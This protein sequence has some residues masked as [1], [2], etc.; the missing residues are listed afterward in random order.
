MANSLRVLFQKIA[1]AQDERELQRRFMDGAGEYFEA[2]HWGIHVLDERSRRTTVDIRGTPDKALLKRSDFFRQQ[3]GFEEAF[4]ALASQERPDLG[5]MVEYYEQ[6]VGQPVDP[7]VRYLIER[8]A[9]AHEET[10]LPSG[11]WKQSKLY[12]C[13][14]ADYG[15]EHMM[16]GPIVGGG[17]LMGMVHFT[18]LGDMPA[19]NAQDLAD[20]SA[21]CAHLSAWLATVRSQPARFNSLLVNRLTKRELEIAELVAQGL[22]N[23]EIGAALWIK[24]DS[25]KQALKRMFRKL[26]VSSRAQMVARLSD[27]LGSDSAR[28]LL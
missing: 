17:Q 16:M 10:V 22:T 18:R 8:H 19:F 9:P 21:L 24:E 6:K 12:Q 27:V 15:H 25:V 28:S 20:L 5:T 3:P 2:Q 1:G 13:C 11:D 14:F 23:A 4:K 26:E 7:I